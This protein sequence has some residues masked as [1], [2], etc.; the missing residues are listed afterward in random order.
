Y[1]DPFPQTYIGFSEQDYI[2]VPFEDPLGLFSLPNAERVR[3][4]NNY[5]MGNQLLFGTLE[6]RV[7]FINLRTLL[8]GTAIL[9][10]TSLSPFVDAGSLQLR[11]SNTG[12]DNRAGTGIEL[13]N[14]LQIEGL[15]IEHSLGIGQPINSFGLDE[16]FDLFY[17]IR[18]TV[19][20]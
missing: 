10:Q 8:L 19:P 11:E 20:F 12:R 15:R 4:Y 14:I 6:Y 5:Q 16:D 2:T 17:R 13:K 9:G 1:G 3:G 7:P 18:A